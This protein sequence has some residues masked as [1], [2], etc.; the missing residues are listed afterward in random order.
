MA[1]NRIPRDLVSR[2]KSARAVYVPPSLLPEP[3]RKPGTSYRWVATHV[4]GGADQ[5]NVSKRMRE[6]WV[7]CKAAD[8]P[9]LMLGAVGNVEVGGLMLCEMPSEMAQARDEYYQKQAQSQTE[10]VDNHYMKNNDPRMPLFS[11]RKS[12]VQRG[13][14]NGS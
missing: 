8:Y 12:S 13:F 14:G 9:E 4:M 1:E 3:A 10:A 2:D 5:T 7:P 11:E 6:G